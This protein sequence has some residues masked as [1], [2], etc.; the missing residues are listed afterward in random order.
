MIVVDSG[1]VPPSGVSNVI[2]GTEDVAGN[3]GCDV[4]AGHVVSGEAVGACDSLSVLPPPAS[5]EVEMVDASLF[6]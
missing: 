6:I 1:L 2:Y 3:V 5:S 4:G